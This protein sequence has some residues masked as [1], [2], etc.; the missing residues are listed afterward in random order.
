MLCPDCQFAWSAAVAQ[1]PV[2]S[3]PVPLVGEVQSVMA[4]AAAASYRHGSGERQKQPPRHHRRYLRR[5]LLL[6][7][8][9]TG[10]RDVQE[11]LTECLTQGTGMSDGQSVVRAMIREG[12]LLERDTN[13]KL[14]I[15]V[16]PHV[17]GRD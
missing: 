13:G 11:V 14:E 10:W 15:A 3:L 1:C 2:R 17:A 5:E 8:R 16:P 9:Q 4:Q 7:L 6:A 12:V